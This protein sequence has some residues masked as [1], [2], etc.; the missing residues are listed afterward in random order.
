[1]S[2]W[3]QVTGYFTYK[4]KLGYPPL[5]LQITENYLNRDVETPDSVFGPSGQVFVYE[6]SKFK[7]GVFEEHGYPGDPLYPM[8]YSEQ[9]FTLSETSLTGSLVKPNLCTNEDSTGYSITD[10]MIISKCLF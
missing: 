1:M 2:T 4:T 5:L 7:Y 8:F 9:S 10:N 3:A 6:W